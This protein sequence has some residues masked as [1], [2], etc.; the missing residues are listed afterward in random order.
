MNRR[1]E[2]KLRKQLITDPSGELNRAQRRYMA[3]VIDRNEHSEI[4]KTVK[5]AEAII[6]SII[7]G[8]S[9]V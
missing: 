1:Q 7:Q 6:R 3:T 4:K 8:E 9:K 5:R 2:E